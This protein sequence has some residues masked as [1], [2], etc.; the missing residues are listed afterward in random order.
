M[1]WF[2]TIFHRNRRLLNFGCVII[3][4]LLIAFSDVTVRPLLGNVALSIFHHPFSELKNSI[5]RLKKVAEDNRNLKNS[6]TEASLRLSS[7]AEA[8]RENRRLREFLGFEPPEN[9]RV[10]P[11]RIVSLGHNQYPIS[12]VINK[13]IND[14]IKINQPVINRFGLVGKIK[15]VMPEFSMVQLLTD[16]A[17]AVSARIAESRQFGIVR[18]LPEEGMIFDNLPADAGINKGD[19]IISSGLGGVYPS[20]LTIAVVDSVFTIKGEIKKSI[21]LKPSAD[22]LE[23]EELYV[24]E[25]VIQ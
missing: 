1:T 13:G 2:S 9:F 21:W 22:F 12:A 10:V 25:S 16:P 5:E 23:I 8:S 19:L 14:S 7:L 6:L 15:E 20:G 18:Y 3:L 17:N 11:V 4:F 24:L